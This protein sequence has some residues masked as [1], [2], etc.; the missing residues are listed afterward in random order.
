MAD[1]SDA[2]G[3]LA[4]EEL[5]ESASRIESLSAQLAVLH[6]EVRGLCRLPFLWS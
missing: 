5:R 4:R 1:M 6:K 2:S 3:H